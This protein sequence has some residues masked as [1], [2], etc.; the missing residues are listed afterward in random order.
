MQDYPHIYKASAA[1]Q[2]KGLVRVSSPGLDDINTSPPPE[3]GGPEGNWSPET[4]MIASV[5]DCFILTFRAIARASKFKWYDL[6]CEVDGKLEKFNSV[7]RFTFL[8]LKARLKVPEETRKG[9]GERLLQMAENNCLITNSMSADIS[10]TT[11]VKLVPEQQ[12]A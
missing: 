3:F 11:E 8:D 10:L 6:E 4:L 7:T 12:V 1:A 5:A 2:P 9:K